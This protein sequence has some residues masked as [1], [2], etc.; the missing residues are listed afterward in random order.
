MAL[1]QGGELGPT[2]T[3]SVPVRVEIQ[4]LRPTGEWSITLKEDGS[5]SQPTRTR[6]GSHLWSHTNEQ[7]GRA[8]VIP[9]ETQRAM[10][11]TLLLL[12]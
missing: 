9:K 5:V 2:W 6:A 1:E 8:K 10:I 12:A 4:A 7:P 11:F 3:A